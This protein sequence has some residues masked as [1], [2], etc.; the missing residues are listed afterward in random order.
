MNHVAELKPGPRATDISPT[1]QRKRM[2]ALG[3][4]AGSAG[5][6]VSER[7]AYLNRRLAD[8]FEKRLAAEKAK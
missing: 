1:E 5:G 3:R 4:I 7:N 6:D 8:E 2:V